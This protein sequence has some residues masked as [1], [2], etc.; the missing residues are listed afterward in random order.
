MKR[1]FRFSNPAYSEGKAIITL[2]DNSL[3]ISRPGLFALKSHGLSGKKI[4]MY[5]Q[6]S[7]VQKKLD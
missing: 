4:I 2:E 1:K 7:A 5:N 3:T 6:I